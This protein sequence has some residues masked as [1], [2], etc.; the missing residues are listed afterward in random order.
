MDRNYK[1]I[2]KYGEDEVIINKSRFIGYAMPIDSEEEALEFGFKTIVLGEKK[3]NPGPQDTE[4]AAKKNNVSLVASPL[5]S[6]EEDP[7]VLSSLEGE[8]RE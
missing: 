7:S 2:Y 1:A 5:P 4:E 3:E 6:L 8:A